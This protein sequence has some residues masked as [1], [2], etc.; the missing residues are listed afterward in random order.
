[1]GGCQKSKVLIYA[2]GKLEG[3][4][5]TIFVL[6]RYDLLQKETAMPNPA[7]PEILETLQKDGSITADERSKFA[8]NHTF[9]NSQ[10]E[11][12]LNEFK[13]QWVAALGNTLYVDNGLKPLQRQL[14]RIPGNRFAYIEQ[15]VPAI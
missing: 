13:G 7:Y 15:V 9:F 4:R 2:T 6:R 1:V 11:R 8:E 12:I 10:R 14:D 3:E 5:L